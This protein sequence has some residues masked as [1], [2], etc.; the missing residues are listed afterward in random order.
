MNLKASNSGSLDYYG[1][2]GSL[3]GD[4][5]VVGAYGEDSN[6]TTITNGTTSNGNNGAGESGA[7]YVY[8]RSGST[9][10][11]EAYVKASNTEGYDYGCGSLSISGDTL[12]VGSVWEG[13]NQ[14]TI[15]NGT[16][17]SADNSN[18]YSGAAY[19]YKRSGSTWQQEAY[20]KA[21]NTGYDDR[22]ERVSLSGD[23]LVVGAKYEDSNQTT[24]TNGTTS[25]ADN[26]ASA[27]G[28]AYVYKRSGTTWSQEAYL[29]ASNAGGNDYYGNSVSIS[30]DTLVVGAYLEDSNQTTIT[31]GTTSSADN[32]TTDSGAAYVYKRS[33][34]TWSQEAYLKA[35]NAEGY[36]YYG[37]SVSISGDTLVVGA[38]LEYSNQTT[39]TNGTT[40][41]ANNSAAESGAA[42]VYRRTQATGTP[43]VSSV[44]PSSGAPAGD[45]II[46]FGG[47]FYSGA[48]A[49][50]GGVNCTTTTV[51]GPNEII[52][53]LPTKPTTG[54]LTVTVT[55]SDATTGSLTSA[56]TYP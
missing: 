12:V 20:L 3:S 28:A 19:V 14:T 36:D 46:I 42:Y 13:S 41:S 33:G 40:S 22:Y 47:N 25:S 39:I 49:S 32:S 52:C 5:L 15:T 55:N 45:N 7:T 43:N 29:K 9:W 44:S 38:Y 4:T 8:K 53:T 2:S 23:T 50:V 30:G 18:A 26:S 35:S 17:S 56:Y 51:Q 34:S 21:S 10:Q 48:V 6:Q 37:Y 1:N 11:Q 31:N 16:T 24:I 27:S 54:A